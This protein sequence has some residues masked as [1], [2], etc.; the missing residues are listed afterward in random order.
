MDGVYVVPYDVEI[1][2]EGGHGR[3]R[4][5]VIT[6]RWLFLAVGG[7]TGGAAGGAIPDLGVVTDVHPPIVEKIRNGLQFVCGRI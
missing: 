6:S 7:T 1:R 2:D 3:I 4:N 5:H